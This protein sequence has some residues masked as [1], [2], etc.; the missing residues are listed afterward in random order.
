VSSVEPTGGSYGVREAAELAGLSP[1]RVRRFV[2]AG[3]VEAR[4]GRH[5]QLQLSFRDLAFLRRVRELERARI[6]PRRVQRALAH[7]RDR[8][9][10]GDLRGVALAAAE[11]EVVV[12]EGRTLWSPDS[13][14]YVFDFERNAT[15]PAV[16]SLEASTQDR[17]QGMS[18][19]AWYRLGCELEGNDRRRAEEAYRLALEL[20]ADHADALINLGCLE[21]EAL[22]FES[23]EEHYR[24]ALRVRDG[25]PTALFNL[26][27]ILEDQERTSEARAAYEATLAADSACAEAHYNL[28]RLCDRL[29]D[30]TGV[31]RHLTAYKRL[32]GD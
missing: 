28:A 8:L 24:A 30:A 20:D 12:R 27:V 4:R 19:D 26:A 10:A 23:A 3:L 29:G 2:R 25:D 11:G 16:V 1:D 7:L 15:A 31:V 5:G 6:A 17:R 13:G 9:H 14:Q 21:H 18:A 22:R 32:S